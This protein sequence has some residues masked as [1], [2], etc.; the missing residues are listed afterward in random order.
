MSSRIV[1]GEQIFEKLVIV[2]LSELLLMVTK[3]ENCLVDCFYNENLPV[4]RN[5]YVKKNYTTSISKRRCFILCFFE[6]T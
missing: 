1:Y 3:K 5:K 2:K 6:K 4:R